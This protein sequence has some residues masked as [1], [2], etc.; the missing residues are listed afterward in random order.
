M[1]RR[2]YKKVNNGQKNARNNN[3]K[4]LWEEKKAKIIKLIN[5]LKCG[6]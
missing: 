4:R 1:A 6:I 2:S 5:K 3:I